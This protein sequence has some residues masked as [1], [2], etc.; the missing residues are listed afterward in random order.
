MY[1]DAFIRISGIAILLLSA[2]IAFR[3]ARST[4]A[5]RLFIGLAITFVATLLTY[6]PENL[7][8]SEP[9]H[10]FV[11][12]IDIPNAV[13]VWL[14]G[15]SLFND[16][17]KIT[18]YHW[19]GGMI[20]CV[21][22]I[23]L[24]LG[25]S[26]VVNLDTALSL[27][28]VD[29]IALGLMGHLFLTTLKGRTDDLLESRR[30]TRFYFVGSMAVTVSLYA[31][32]DLALRT[33]YAASVPTFKAAIALPVIVWAAWW[34]MNVTP[35]K[36][37]FETEMKPRSLSFKDRELLKKLEQ[38]FVDTEAYLEP[39]LTIDGLAE[40]VGS[41]AYRL[42]GLI[43]QEMGHR[44]FSSYINA[45]RI[46]AV[47]QAFRDPKNEDVPILTIA[48]DSGFNSISPFNRAFK[49]QEGLTPSEFRKRLKSEVA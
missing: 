3:D 13:F 26:G 5:A 1:F 11:R 28:L 46:A 48:L 42:R 36:L 24:R 16:E 15:L 23:V 39:G 18:R 41:T 19:I 47:K 43:N 20:Y 37:I 35:Q 2:A 40:R 33:S 17:L 45:M 34:L 27:I 14:F 12:I 22:V 10:S 21:A 49:A 31:L 32:A 8:L 30:R 7:S 4:M 29:T 6:T 9:I 38:E 25:Q 44:H